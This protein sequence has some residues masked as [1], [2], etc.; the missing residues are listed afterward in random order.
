[1]NRIS[2][3]VLGAGALERLSARA[4]RNGREIGEE[5]AAIVERALQRESDA[6]SIAAGIRANL[7]G[8]EHTDSELL[9]AEDRGR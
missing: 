9:L 8:R 5:V 6:A 2:L 3:D 4:R 7:S 1:M